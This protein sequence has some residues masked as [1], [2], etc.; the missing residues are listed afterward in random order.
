M[1]KIKGLTLL[2]SVMLTAT[3]GRVTYNGHCES[4]YNLPMRRV[5]ARAYE[6]GIYGEYWERADGCKML[7]NKIIVAT[8]WDVYPYGSV[9]ETSRGLGISLDTGKFKGN[10]VDI[11]TTW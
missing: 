2:L 1:K 7:G 10:I 3:L 8:D 11:A 6:N 5:V 4:W 9:I